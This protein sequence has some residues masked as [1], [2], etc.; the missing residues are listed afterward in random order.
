MI[1]QPAWQFP[2]TQ[3]FPSTSGFGSITAR[4]KIL[5]QINAH[6]ANRD[7][8]YTLRSRYSDSQDKVVSLN[9]F[10][11]QADGGFVATAEF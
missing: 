9:V 3:D 8:Q 2:I 5:L 10:E 1:P 11:Q 6:V 7:Y 4:A